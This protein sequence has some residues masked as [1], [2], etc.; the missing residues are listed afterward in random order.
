MATR[1]SATDTS[2][3]S[4]CLPVSL[5]PCLPVSL[6]PCLP[7]SLSPCLPVSLSPCLPLSLSPC[8]PVSLSPCLPVSLSPLP[9]LPSAYPRPPASNPYNQ[10]PVATGSPADAQWKR[11]VVQRE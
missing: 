3:L 7:V 1:S 9:S 6:S 8:L 10:R 2:S 11:P 4:P 5:S